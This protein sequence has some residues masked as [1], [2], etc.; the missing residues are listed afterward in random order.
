LCRALQGPP[1]ASQLL[2]AARS[3]SAAAIEA[4]TE[5]E[6]A[7][8]QKI[9]AGLQQAESI[10]VQDT[11]GGCGTMYQ[12]QVVSPDFAGKSIVKQHQTVTKLLQDDIKQWHGF[13]LTTKAPESPK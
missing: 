4:G 6:K 7:I 13:H 12:I 3:F 2:T 5:A 1:S 11:S 9:L 10:S 8:A